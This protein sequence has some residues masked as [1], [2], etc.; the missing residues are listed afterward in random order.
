MAVAE[1]GVHVAGLVVDDV[2]EILSLGRVLTKVFDNV[3]FGG[4]GGGFPLGPERLDGDVAR[5]EVRRGDRDEVPLVHDRDA[6]QGLGAGQVHPH[7]LR[8]VGGREEHLT[9]QHSGK[10][11]VGGVHAAR[12][13]P[14]RA[15]TTSSAG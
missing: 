7:E 8:S 10:M 4:L 14:P 5:V 1:G 2:P 12:P 3:L 9:V 15:P 6:R 13:S 11:E